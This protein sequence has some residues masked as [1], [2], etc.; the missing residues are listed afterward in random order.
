MLDG[1]IVA[2]TRGEQGLLNLSS[3]ML[4]D[5]APLYLQT[6]FAIKQPIQ[7]M[8]VAPTSAKLNYK[9]IFAATAAG[10]NFRLT[11]YKWL[12]LPSSKHACIMQSKFAN[13]SF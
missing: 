11:V 6:H 3:C 1:F 10:Q 9:S 7:M 8:M 2:R 12:K 5:H 4:S 13:G